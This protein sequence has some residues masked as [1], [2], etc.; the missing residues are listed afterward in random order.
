V[1]TSK[2]ALTAT[3]LFALLLLF[4]GLA[5]ADANPYDAVTVPSVERM[6][7]G[8]E[9]HAVADPYSGLVFVRA[10]IGD[11]PLAGT[12]IVG[13]VGG[14]EL[15]GFGTTRFSGSVEVMTH[16]YPDGEL[17]VEIAFGDGPLAGSLLQNRSATG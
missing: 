12:V 1:T 9:I 17:I 16:R 4:A 15:L 5:A 3:I 10:T 13:S 2:G 11:G 8:A 7:A 6:S 14:A